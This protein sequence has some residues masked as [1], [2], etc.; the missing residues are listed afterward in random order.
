LLVPAASAE[1]H[2]ELTMSPVDTK[3]ASMES[4]RCTLFSRVWNR[5]VN[6]F[7][8]LRASD[9]APVDP[10]SHFSLREWAD[11]PTHHPASD[12]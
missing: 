4:E 10:T 11:L 8:R 2:E 6:W 9:A 5:V 3:I 12:E 1:Q 7:D